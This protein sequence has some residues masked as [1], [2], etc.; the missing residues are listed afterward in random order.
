MAEIFSAEAHRDTVVE[1]SGAFLE[2][3]LDAAAFST[4]IAQVGP[5]KAVS[6]GTIWQLLRMFSMAWTLY[7]TW[8]P[9]G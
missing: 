9:G 7:L 1:A 2:G 6:D 5:P 3:C 8:M 4:A